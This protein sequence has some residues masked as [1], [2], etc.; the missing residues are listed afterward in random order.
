MKILTS[1]WR[2]DHETLSSDALG[3]LSASTISGRKAPDRPRSLTVSICRNH[4]RSLPN[5]EIKAAAYLAVLQEMS[6][7]SQRRYQPR[8][9]MLGCFV[10]LHAIRS[11]KP[12]K[13]VLEGRA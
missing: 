4:I 1:I 9:N 12:P 3:R 11:A 2:P 6:K 13:P 8:L 7:G 10:L 5:T